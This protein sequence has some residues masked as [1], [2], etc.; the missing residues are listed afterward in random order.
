MKRISYGSLSKHIL[1]MADNISDPIK[2][3]PRFSEQLCYETFKTKS[4]AWQ[5]VTSVKKE[6]QG[7][8][9]ALNLPTS[10]ANSIG[11]RIFQELS[12]SE[13][14]G[15]SGSEH[16]WTYM[17][18][19]FQKDSMVQMCENIKEFTLFKR[20]ESQPIK[21]YINEFESLYMKAKKKGLTG[22]PAE[23]LTFLLFENSG[24]ETKDQRLAMV[25]VD[26][27]QK[28]EMF[29]KSKK[30]LMKL[31]GGIKSLT[32]DVPDTIRVLDENNTFF[33]RRNNSRGGHIG[34]FQRGVGNQ[35]FTAPQYRSSGTAS[36][37]GT[38]PKILSNKLN[39]QKF[40]KPMECHQCGARTHL[41]SACPEL[42][43]WTFMNYPREEAEE[44]I[45]ALASQHSNLEQEEYLEITDERDVVDHVAQAAA[46]L[47]NCDCTNSSLFNTFHILFTE[48]KQKTLDVGA[49]KGTLNKI[50]LDTG[51][52]KTV[53]GKV[54]MNHLISSM[55]PESRRLIKISKSNNGFKF[56]VG[57]AQRSLGKY[58]V[59]I[60]LGHMN[61]MLNTDVIATDIPCL[62]SKDAMVKSNMVINMS[63]NTIKMFGQEVD[64]IDVPS[65]HSAINV[66]AF[67]MKKLDEFYS[68][69]TVSGSE[70]YNF[71]RIQH[72][73]EQLGHPSLSTMQTMLK[74][75]S[76]LNENIKALLI[77]V[78]QSCATCAIHRKAKTRPKVS[79][80]ISQNF[81]DTVCM[82]LKIW[83]KHNVIILYIIDVFSRFTAA[84]I[85]PNI[86]ESAIDRLNF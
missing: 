25:E 80:P 69:V 50:I 6:S 59:P 77:K 43:G 1:K 83:P 54:W 58:V 19:Q 30:N 61:F 18:K 53:T 44:M 11:E 40:G 45:A 39:P 10:E 13:L 71:K 32:D 16:F 73:H 35:R 75:A 74:N 5:K 36:G 29:E 66:E 86:Q 9:L 20:K 12:I 42:N 21:D 4:M 48:Q 14:E 34:R 51:C 76:I 55:G 47:E 56:G 52:I 63:N 17:D 70:P 23:Y 72:I 82:D 2:K 15:E 64:M 68:F 78:Y 8:V 85:I 65:G 41:M 57:E 28:D 27:S 49:L 37:G 22:L 33:N 38:N 24:L 60:K 84:Y 31:F 62:L 46:V 79:A 7:L 67:N 26:F 3:P 81:N